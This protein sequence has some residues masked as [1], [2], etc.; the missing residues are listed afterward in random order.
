MQFYRSPLVVF[1]PI[2][3]STFIAFYVVS[4]KSPF[5]LLFGPESSAHNNSF[6]KNSKANKIFFIQILSQ[7]S[8]GI[9][10]SSRDSSHGRLMVHGIEHKRRNMPLSH[11]AGAKRV[12]KNTN[13]RWMGDDYY[14]RF[15]FRL[16]SFL[17]PLFMM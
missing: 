16:P 15:V 5:R 11:F 2:N 6:S 1:N 17:C 4:L 13:R 7:L 12:P 3:L 14:A 9:I 8:F 10:I